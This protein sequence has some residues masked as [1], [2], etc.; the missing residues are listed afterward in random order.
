MIDRNVLNT[1]E[2]V[3][4]AAILR[5]EYQSSGLDNKAFAE[6]LNKNEEHRAKFRRPL[7]QSHVANMLTAL[8]MTSNFSRGGVQVPTDVRRLTERVTD[9]EQELDKLRAT[10]KGLSHRMNYSG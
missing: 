3:D 8:G 5:S 7:T 6:W 4:L 1:I 10:V 9:L 2:T